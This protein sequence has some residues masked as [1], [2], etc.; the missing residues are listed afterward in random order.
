MN[1]TLSNLDLFVFRVWFISIGSWVYGEI[2]GS[3]IKLLA[4]K[5]I[6]L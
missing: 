2:D 5:R 4:L 3:P 6:Y 1:T